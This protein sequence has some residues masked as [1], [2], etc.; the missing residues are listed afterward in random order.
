MPINIP[1][2]TTQLVAK[3]KKIFTEKGYKFFEGTYDLNI[4]GLRSPDPTPN[5]FNDIILVV[6][7]NEAKLWM[8][9]A[10]QATTDPGLYWMLNP[11]NTRGTAIVAEQQARKVWKKGLHKGLPALVQVNPIIVIRDFNKDRKLDY[12]SA[13]RETG[14]FAINMHRSRND[15]VATQVVDKWSAGCQV[16]S[17]NKDMERILTLVDLQKKNGNGEFVTYTLIKK[18]LVF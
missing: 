2:T 14:V 4:I 10:F 12:N 5:I 13:R 7:Q 16:L 18:E 15:G 8:V 3:L 6:Y 1:I 11:E 17:L 9:E